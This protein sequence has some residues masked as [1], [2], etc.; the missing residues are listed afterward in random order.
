MSTLATI[1]LCLLAGA[2]FARQLF[3]L[4]R[5]AVLVIGFAF[6]SRVALLLTPDVDWS[7]IAVGAFGT[8][9]ILVAGYRVIHNA[10]VDADLRRQIERDRQQAAARRI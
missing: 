8:A 4:L 6:A 3:Q 5:I 2:L 7:P 10:L 9:V 1:I